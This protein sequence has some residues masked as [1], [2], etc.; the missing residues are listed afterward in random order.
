[1]LQIHLIL[2]YLLEF[3][4]HYFSVIT[5]DSSIYQL[6]RTARLNVTLQMCSQLIC[7]YFPE[8]IGHPLRHSA[9]RKQ[10]Y[11]LC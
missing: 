1:M 5:L 11:L 4:P 2:C 3:Y 9:S 10:I 8:N 7:L 6:A